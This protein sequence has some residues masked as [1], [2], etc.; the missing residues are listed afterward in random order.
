LSG[1]VAEQALEFGAG[2]RKLA[3]P[4]Q[5]ARILQAHF[6]RL[7][8]GGEMAAQGL[9]RRLGR[10]GALQLR[11]EHRRGVPIGAQGRAPCRLP[12]RRADHS[13]GMQRRLGAGVVRLGQRR[14]RARVSCSMMASTACLSG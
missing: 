12:P 9:Q 6:A 3:R 10:L 13:V 11:L 1:K 14:R 7:R 8:M 2:L 5:A 4:D